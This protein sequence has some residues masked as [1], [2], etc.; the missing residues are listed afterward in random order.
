VQSKRAVEIE[1]L[2]AHAEVEPL[3]A[4]AAQLRELAG[5]GGPATVEAYVRNAKIPLHR[6]TRQL[7]LAEAAG[8]TK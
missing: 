6:K 2:N 8:G 5:N 4:L 7:I 3:L 1:T